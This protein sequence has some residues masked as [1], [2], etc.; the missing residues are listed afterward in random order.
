MGSPMNP[1]SVCEWHHVNQSGTIRRA[2]YLGAPA[3]WDRDLWQWVFGLRIL[4]LH[5]FVRTT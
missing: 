2:R 4:Y 5:D 3:D 1:D